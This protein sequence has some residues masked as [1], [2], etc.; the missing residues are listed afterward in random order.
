MRTAVI[1]LAQGHASRWRSGGSKHLL[2]VGDRPVLSR[3]CAMVGRHLAPARSVLVCRKALYG[4]V[5][6]AGFEHYQD[7]DMEADLLRRILSTSTFWADRT[8]F[9]LGDVFF[10]HA[11]LDALARDESPVAFL[12]RTSANLITGK[13]WPEL[14]GM[15]MTGTTQSNTAASLLRVS[16]HVAK[17][18]TEARL[19]HVYRALSGLPLLEN[20]RDPPLYRSPRVRKNYDPHPLLRPVMDWTDDV[21]TEMEREKYYPTLAG[22]AREDDRACP[23]CS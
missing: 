15:L 3:T 7:Q 16:N 9:L 12:G 11:A 23:L 8:I 1:V 10:S 4:D 2:P 13:P 18:G 17:A 21:D 19:W 5:R 22:L 14:F 6:P 20:R